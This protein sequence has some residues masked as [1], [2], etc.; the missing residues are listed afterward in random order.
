MAALKLLTDEDIYRA[1]APK[2]REFGFDVISTPEC[3]RRAES[4]LSQLSYATAEDR[5]IVTFNVG[6]FV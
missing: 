1:V 4:D 6:H 2:L 5:A 3:G